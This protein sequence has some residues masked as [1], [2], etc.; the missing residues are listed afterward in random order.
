MEYE[1]NG[2]R[3]VIQDTIICEFD[4]FGADEGRGKYR[5]WKQRLASGNERITL[6]KVDDTKEIYYNEGSA[7][8]YM[9]DYGDAEFQHDFPNASM[10]TKEG[11]TTSYGGIPAEELQKKYNIKL[12]S[13]DYTSPIKN[14][15]Y[16]TKK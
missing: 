8:Y 7:E 1:I 5:K 12:I 11:R 2:E 14:K 4:G 10:I 3:K 16:T 6:L 9:G 13:W 15:F